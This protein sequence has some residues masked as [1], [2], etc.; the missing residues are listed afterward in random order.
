MKIIRAIIFLIL[1][2]YVRLA[3]PVRYEYM[4]SKNA[5]PAIQEQK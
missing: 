3:T 5:D 1:P 4:E 2:T